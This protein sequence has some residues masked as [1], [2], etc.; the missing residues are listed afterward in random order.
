MDFKLKDPFETISQIVLAS[1][2][3]KFVPPSE[4]QVNYVCV[5]ARA[6]NIPV[7]PD[8]VSTKASCHNFISAYVDDFRRRFE[9]PDN[10]A[11]KPNKKRRTGSKNSR[12]REAGLI[13]GAAER[14]RS[15]PKD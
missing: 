7:T 9:Q 2:D 8:T 13:E 15:I 14:N 5:I 10:V 12:A 4:A 1:L 11:S 3:S 6:L